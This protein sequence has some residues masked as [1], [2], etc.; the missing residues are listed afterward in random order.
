[1]I[2][3]SAGNPNDGFVYLSMQGTDAS[4]YVIFEQGSGFLLSDDKVLTAAH[5]VYNDNG[6]L[7]HHW[8]GGSR[9]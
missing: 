3:I 2:N 1:M 5:L 7:A 6:N 8:L 9:L 4:V